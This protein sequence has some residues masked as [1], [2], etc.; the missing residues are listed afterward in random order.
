ME[1]LLY[2]DEDLWWI[3][4]NIHNFRGGIKEIETYKK[5][6][7]PLVFQAA[8]TEQ[9]HIIQLL[10]KNGISEKEL[11]KIFEYDESFIKDML[12]L[13]GD[14]SN[15][16]YNKFGKTKA[17]SLDYNNTDKLIF[18]ARSS[19]E[20]HLK[21][22][23][24]QIKL[25]DLRDIFSTI[26]R[27][28]ICFEDGH[29]DNYRLMRDVPK[30]YDDLAVKGISIRDEMFPIDT[31]DIGLAI[32]EDTKHISQGIYYLSEELE[33]KSQRDLLGKNIEKRC[34]EIKLSGTDPLYDEPHISEREL[35]EKRDELFRKLTL[36]VDDTY[37]EFVAG[38]MK[39][40]YDSTEK[41]DN[42]IDYI[43]EHKDVKSSELL[44][45]LAKEEDF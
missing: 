4:E 11:A 13:E 45:L 10:A 43:N 5:I 35:F 40:A 16:N 31:V 39:Y 22:K 41:I 23:E 18:H 28:S 8:M 15:Y 17:L 21:E 1:F 26:D 42:L 36:E 14:L 6:L 25:K 30:E 9:M 20:A 29:Y 37:Y 24:K 2:K 12:E 19:E 3:I 27:V 32:D 33:T 44:K 7:K 38:V 34:I